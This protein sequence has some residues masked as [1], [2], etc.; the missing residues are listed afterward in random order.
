MSNIKGKI[1]NIQ[2]FCTDDGE[3]IR[4]TVFFKGCPL[5]C[6]WCHNPE[7]QSRENELLYDAE[8]CVDCMRCVAVCPTG[9]QSQANRKHTFDR[10]LC[11][12]CGKCIS[13]SC[14]ALEIKGIY[15]TSE[16]IL[17]EVI[18][19]KPYYDNSGG[20]ITLSGGEPLYQPEFC[21]D[22]L[23]KAKERGLHICMETCGFANED[24]VRKSAEW[25]DTYLFDIKETD[26]ERHKK[27]TGADNS[28]ILKSLNLID[29]LGKQIVLRCPLI[30][31]VNDRVS[32]AKEIA[33]IANGLNNVTE[34]VI[35]PY[36]SFGE[37]KYAR[38]GKPYSLSH[39]SPPKSDEIEA[40]AKELQKST[41]I[42]VKRA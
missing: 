5:R 41:E 26:S 2:R 24:A 7:S 32:H 23:K 30:P 37:S 33:R 9:A 28:L 31:T 13:N 35:E 34:I 42:P 14:D 25:V 19:D 6:E 38:L 11:K 3:G 36:H 15:V 18:K 27:Y 40:F 10:A 8:R 1:L 16:E 29:S 39:L 4:T 22:L 20:G 21:F 12:A 17:D